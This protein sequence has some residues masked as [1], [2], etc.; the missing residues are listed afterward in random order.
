MFCSLGRIW[1]S[2]ICQTRYAD[3]DCISSTAFVWENRAVLLMLKYV[4]HFYLQTFYCS[5]RGTISAVTVHSHGQSHHAKALFFKLSNVVLLRQ[6]TANSFLHLLAIEIVPLLCAL[7]N[8]G[9]HMKMRASSATKLLY[10]CEGFRAWETTSFIVTLLAA[11]DRCL[12]FLQSC[13]LSLFVSQPR[14]AKVSDWKASW[15]THATWY[16]LW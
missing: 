6:S 7:L 2:E 16:Y 14:L 8:T 4:A 10:I 9:L 12:L 1:L 13:R 5:E 11:V 15:S 3:C